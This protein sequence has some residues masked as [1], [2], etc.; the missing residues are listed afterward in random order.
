[1][2]KKKTSKTPDT[3]PFEEALD[4][5]QQIV[6]QLEEGS[7]GLEDSLSR[8]ETGVALL[9]TCY[10]V[11]EKAEQNIEILTGIDADGNPATEPFDATATIDQSSGS[12]GRRSRGTS[13]ATDDESE[14]TLF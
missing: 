10:S 4:E 5:L 7:L 6:G 9:R 2:A 8:F 14:S 1:M 13:Q 3:P 11:L 12:A